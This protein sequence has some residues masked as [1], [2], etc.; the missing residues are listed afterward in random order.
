MNNARFSILKKNMESHPLLHYILQ[1][2]EI[3]REDIPKLQKVCTYW[4]YSISDDDVNSYHKMNE[5]SLIRSI[6]IPKNVLNLTINIWL[7]KKNSSICLLEDDTFIKPNKLLSFY[8]LPKLRSLSLNTEFNHLL[9]SQETYMNLRTLI[10]DHCGSCMMSIPSELPNLIELYIDYPR[11]IELSP[12][13]NIEIFYSSKYCKITNLPPAFPKMRKFV[14]QSRHLTELPHM[15]E[16]EELCIRSNMIELPYLHKLRALRCYQTTIKTLPEMPNIEI[17]NCYG[18][19]M[20]E[21]LP[22]NMPKLRSLKIGQTRI[23][24]LPN[25]PNICVLDI[26]NTRIIDLPD[27][28]PNIVS[29]NLPYTKKYHHHKFKYLLASDTKSE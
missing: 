29:I 9:F 23:K 14:Y 7:E 24:H 16:L 1:F 15:P 12:M 25:M 13:P 4:K 19:H 20:L 6:N 8:N 2:L 11:D 10:I 5:Y 18:C 26:D 28:M 3:E 27:Y 22:E 17:L 21:R